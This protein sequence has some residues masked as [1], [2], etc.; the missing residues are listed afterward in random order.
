MAAT[1]ASGKIWQQQ[2]HMEVKPELTSKP[3]VD[4]K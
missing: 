4:S 2:Q 3:F 1:P